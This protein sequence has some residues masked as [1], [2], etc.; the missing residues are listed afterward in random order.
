MPEIHSDAER[1]KCPTGSFYLEDGNHRA[2]IYAMHIE[3]GK[4]KYSPVDAIHATSWDIAAGLLN[5]RP[6]KAD[7]LEH[8]GKL[9]DKKCL[10]NEFQLPI[11]IQI[12][13]YER[14]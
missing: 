11:G 2:L 12:N 7:S 5:F 8:N 9:Q 3:F 14:P 10:Q 1:G 4:M 6:Q 13:T